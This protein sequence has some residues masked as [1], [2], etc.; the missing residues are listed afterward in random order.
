MY[1]CTREYSAEIASGRTLMKVCISLNTLPPRLVTFW[2]SVDC[3][4]GEGSSL[5][6]NNIVLVL[7]AIRA[8]I[9]LQYEYMQ[10]YDRNAFLFL[11]SCLFCPELDGVAVLFGTC[12]VLASVSRS[13]PMKSTLTMQ[14]CSHPTPQS[15]H[16]LS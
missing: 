13:S 16:L 12:M 7:Y 11:Y 4:C 8:S 15:G 5:F 14:R 6:C 10:V 9:S 2:A 1:R 3:Y